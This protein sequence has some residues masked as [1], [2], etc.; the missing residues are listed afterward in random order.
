M[1]DHRGRG[2]ETARRAF[3]LGATSSKVALENILFG[4]DICPKSVQKPVAERGQTQMS[5]SANTALGFLALG[6]SY[7]EETAFG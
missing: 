4:A 5:R 6:I 1:E 2:A 7:V 3:E